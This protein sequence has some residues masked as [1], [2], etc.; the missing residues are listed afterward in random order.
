MTGKQLAQLKQAVLFSDD[1]ARA[2]R[3]AGE[4]LSSQIDA[5]LDVWYGFVGG[6]PHLA[7]PSAMSVA[8]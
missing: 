7:T 6:H 5:I 1:D 2:L 4:V 3:A 8:C